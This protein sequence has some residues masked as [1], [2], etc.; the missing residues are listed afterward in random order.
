MDLEISNLKNIGAVRE[1]QAVQ[2]QFVSRVFLT[3]KQ[4]GRKRF[5]LNL[6]QLNAFI[7]APHFKMEDVRT[8]SRLIQKGWFGAT[9]D[10]K[11]AYFLVPI[12]K[13]HRKFLRFSHDKVLY[14]FTCL[15]FG[16]ASAP[17]AFTKIIKPVIEYLHSR[18]VTCVSYLDDFLVLGVSNIECSKNIQIV[19]NVLQTLGFIINRDK[20]VLRPST[21]FRFLGFIFN[22]NSMTIELP[23]EKRQNIGNQIKRYL[24]YHSCTIIEFAQLLGLLISSCPAI[25]YGWL[26]TKPLEKAK[27]F[28][29]K[30][31]Q[32]NYN[33]TML[34]SNESKEELK[35]WLEAIQKSKNDLRTDNF[36]LEIFSDAS[37]SGWGAYCRGKSVFGWW[38]MSQTKHHINILELHAIFFGLKSFASNL[39]NC[40]IL[41]RTDNTTALS[42]VNRMG[43]V[44]FP[45]LNTLA[46]Q[47]WQWCETRNIWVFASYI[48]SSENCQ[49]DLA[50]RILPTETE[51]ALCNEMFKIIVKKFGLPNIDL[52][53]SIANRKCRRYI[54]WMTDPESEVVDAFTVSW[55]NLKFYA[56][57]PFSLI[58][59][60]LQKIINDQATG[61]MVV[62]L[63]K[64]QPWYP[65]F[66]KLMVGEPLVLG[67]S[68]DMLFCPYSKVVHPLRKDLTLVV[69]ILS[70][71]H[72]DL[73]EYPK[74]L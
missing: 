48:Q 58:L 15:P 50:S 2:G 65:L 35:W 23:R 27:F 7:V 49:A 40:S 31:S 33:D 73:R 45:K 61:I 60:A 74:M 25:K 5:I 22:S 19:T 20:S 67:P 59:R 18:G 51:W 54:S 69:A 6:K 42:Y 30:L 64:A 10:L 63:W 16:L 72:F 70:G 71:K 17:Y 21:Q 14:A 24:K 34:V 41:I 43:S 37:L 38:T 46:R 26:Y 56:F 4:N 32:G 9:V 28:A 47:I 1:C 39:K 29:L 12:Q 11:D 62:P 8:A 55:S 53:A 68:N 3:N 57:P 52:F 36:S 66:L 13:S 44:K